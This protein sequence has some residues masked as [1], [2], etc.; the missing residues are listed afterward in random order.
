MKPRPRKAETPRKI[1]TATVVLIAIVVV[2]QFALMAWLGTHGMLV[3]LDFA[4]VGAAIASAL[5]IK[6]LF[7]FSIY[8]ASVRELVVV[9][10]VC[11]ALHVALFLG[12]SYERSLQRRPAATGSSPAAP[13]ATTY[14]ETGGRSSPGPASQDTKR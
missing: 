3:L 1:R 14:G 12:T 5:K 13:P 2:V 7:G 6:R 9:V 10:A 4:V 8:Q 11:A